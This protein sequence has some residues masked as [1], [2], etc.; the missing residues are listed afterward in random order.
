MPAEVFFEVERRLALLGWQ[1]QSERRIA[2]FYPIFEAKIDQLLRRF[3]DHLST[4]PEVARILAKH[5]IAGR[6]I[7]AQWTHWL[8]L[9]QCEFTEEYVLRARRIGQ[10]HYRLQVP[11]YAYIGSYTF[12]QTLILEEASNHVR[13]L[14]LAPL[15]GDISRIISL[16]MELS[17]AAYVR[18]HWRDNQRILL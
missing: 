8:K 2:S 18:E 13:G 6:L 14:D 16:D 12:M 17:I 11:V 3:Y 10:A 1:S 15:L 7:P 5:D 9:F 4:C